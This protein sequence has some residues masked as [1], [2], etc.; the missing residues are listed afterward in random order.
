MKVVFDA[1]VLISGF[2][3]VTGSSQ[4]IVSR[5]IKRHTVLISSYILEEFRDRLIRKLKMPPDIVQEA[6]H[7]LKKRT[8]LIEPSKR[9]QFQ[10]PDPK[11]IPILNLIHESKAHYFVTGDKQLLALKKLGSTVFLSSREAMEIL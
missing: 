1:N 11:D 7:F 9:G 10:F 6:V 2:L 8:I 3:T 4:L 5:A